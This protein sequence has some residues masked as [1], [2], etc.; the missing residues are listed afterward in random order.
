MSTIGFVDSLQ[1]DAL[2]AV[3]AMGRNLTFTAVVVLT[4]AVGI[5]A[6]AAV[7]SVLNG[8][9]L[10]PLPYPHSEELVALR[11]V[12]PGAA[13]SG[14]SGALSLSPSMYLTYAENNR[15]FQSLGAWIAT[16]GTVTELGDPE[17][18]RAIGISSGVLGTFDVPP[19]AGRWLAAADQ[20]TH[21]A[22]AERVQGL[23]HGDAEP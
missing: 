17:Q 20:T 23:F 5:G 1:R 14:S 18:V 4:L 9:L 13:G 8:V 12:A 19:A 7:F 22:A 15:V 10:E 16:S 3:R 11:H 2:Y 21:A 6:N